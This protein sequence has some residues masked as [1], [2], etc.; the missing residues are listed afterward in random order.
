MSVIIKCDYWSVE[1]VPLPELGASPINYP[2]LSVNYKV[3]A[4]PYIVGID[5]L[6]GL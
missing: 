1:G 6:F 2:Y 4:M 3:T 5:H